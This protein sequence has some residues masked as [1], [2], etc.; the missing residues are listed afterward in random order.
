MRPRFF[1]LSVCLVSLV[2][3]LTLWGFLVSFNIIGVMRWWTLEPTSYLLMF[4]TT[5]FTITTIAGAVGYFRKTGCGLGI[6]FA[7]PFALTIPTIPNWLA[8]RVTF[9]AALFYSFEIS[10][11]IIVIEV[12]FVVAL[13]QSPRL[14]PYLRYERS[15]PEETIFEK[16]FKFYFKFHLIMGTV[17]ISIAGVALVLLSLLSYLIPS[18]QMVWTFCIFLATS[19]LVLFSIALGQRVDHKL[20]KMKKAKVSK[21]KIADYRYWALDSYKDA[22]RL[23]KRFPYTKILSSLIDQAKFKKGSRILELGAGAG[24]LCVWLAKTRPDL[25]ILGLESSDELIQLATKHLDEMGVSNRIQIQKGDVENLQQFPDDSFDAVISMWRVHTWD[26]PASVF[27]EVSRILKEGGVICISAARRDAGFL[28]R[29]ARKSAFWLIKGNI[30]QEFDKIYQECYTI[31]ELKDILS[32]TRLKNYVLKIKS[33]EII[34]HT[35]IQ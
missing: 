21:E 1:S 14:R 11:V 7:P 15:P 32:K 17:M 35:A 16:A 5:F 20:L 22:R 25:Q 19:V 31:E 2:I 6:L 28:V 30:S 8:L 3:A 26:S 10:V 29:F 23:F 33:K 9:P 24:W 27:D 18:H 12:V 34:I 13:G 4:L